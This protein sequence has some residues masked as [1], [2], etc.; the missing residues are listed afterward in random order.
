MNVL[1]MH[2]HDSGRY[3]QPYGYPIPMP[4]TMKLSDQSV[5]FRNAYCGGP[6][7]SPSRAALT[8]GQAC[9][10]TGLL[11]LAHRGFALADRK[12]HLSS[13]LATQGFETVLC[14]VQHE[15]D[16][17]SELGYTRILPF[18]D[19]IHTPG[20]DTV[21]WDQTNARTVAAFLK[22]EHDKPFFLS[23]GMFN[24]HRPYP[25][26]AL[27]HINPDR[28][29]PPQTVAD[30]PENREDMAD[31]QC[32]AQVADA[33]VGIVLDALRETGH[34]D[35]TVVLLT[36]DHGIAWPFMKCN[37]Y[38]SGIGVAMLLRYPGN[39]AAGKTCE[40]LVSQ[41]DVFPTLCELL[42]IEKPDWLQGYSMLP[43]IQKDEPIRDAVFAEVNY[44]AAYEPMRCV[45]TERYKLIVRYD[46]YLGVVAPNIDASPSKET[47]HAAGY[48]DTL[49]PREELFDLTVDPMERHNLVH[50]PFCL[51]VYQDLQRRLTQWMAE[52]ED[53][54][55]HCRYRIPAPKNARVN[56]RDGYDPE[57][58]AMEAG[59]EAIDG[60][61]LTQSKKAL[62]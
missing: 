47:L 52:T 46:D 21:A 12:R 16:G 25:N 8:C 38:D 50:D 53:P 37:L 58:C 20:L 1:Y 30:T 44:H 24:T 48:L 56:R 49:R 32:S 23:Y 34:E 9:H 42:G 40:H 57:N 27:H 43:A 39:P 51:S 17:D 31:Y 41:V 18:E 6:T 7:C 13:Y 11:G 28:V 10:S 15:A 54:L 59:E 19:W 29:M 14:G 60:I 62:Q 4:N 55:L 36:T 2:T 3:W 26:H 33:C 35:D 5:L 45:R 61:S 22:E